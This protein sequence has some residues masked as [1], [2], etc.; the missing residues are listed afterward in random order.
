[1]QRF[2]VQRLWLKVGSVGCEVAIRG[3]GIKVKG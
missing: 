2:R 1:M 3:E